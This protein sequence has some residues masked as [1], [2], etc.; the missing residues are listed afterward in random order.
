MWRGRW[1]SGHTHG[2]TLGQVPMCPY[3]HS[4]DVNAVNKNFV[5]TWLGTGNLMAR[6]KLSDE[7]S[8]KAVKFK[9]FALV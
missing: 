2:G 3:I 6:V 9:L 5:R 4:N 1:A 8:L 7:G